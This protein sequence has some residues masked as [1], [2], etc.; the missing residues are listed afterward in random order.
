MGHFWTAVHVGVRFKAQVHHRSDGPGLLGG[1][2]LKS[3]LLDPSVMRSLPNKAVDVIADKLSGHRLI[4][5]SSTHGSLDTAPASHFRFRL[6]SLLYDR[7]RGSVAQRLIDLATHPKSMQ[8]NRQ[9]PRYRY[10][11]SLLCVL[12]TTL[13]QPQPV[14]L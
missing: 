5:A 13:A 9:L 12:S 8:Q 10:C 6:R 1:C 2:Y 11:G 7:P 14:T 3:G 4:L